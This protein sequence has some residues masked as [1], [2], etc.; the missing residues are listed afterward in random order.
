MADDRRRRRRRRR[1]TKY[2]SVASVERAYVEVVELF[3]ILGQRRA[4]LSAQAP[5]I[6]TRPV[7]VSAN[8]PCE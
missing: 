8:G 4:V 1:T 6:R 3:E 5:V 2:R 7:H